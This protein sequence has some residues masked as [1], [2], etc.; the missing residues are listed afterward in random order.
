M[1]HIKLFEEFMSER[2]FED[3]QI[4]IYD[5]EDGLTYI[6]KRGKSY[7]GYN[8]KFDFE[9][10]DKAEL[11]KKLKSWKYKLISGSVEESKEDYQVYHNTYSS[12]VDA[13][14]EYAKSKG[15]E[16]VQDDVWNK[17]SVGPKKPSDGQT[18]KAT[19]GLLKGEK[20][21]RKALQMQIYGMGNRYE[22]N[23]YIN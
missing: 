20:P 14:L 3:G 7:Y 10:K 5:G 18:N 2:T 4:A 8:D 12:A 23:A 6:E 11:E 1:K 19:I 16:I 13:A 22:L 17:I 21:Q 9:A 15:Y